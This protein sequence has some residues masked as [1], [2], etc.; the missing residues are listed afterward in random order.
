MGTGA[1]DGGGSLMA[2]F[3]MVPL[4]A[5]TDRTLTHRD[6]RTLLAVGS[7]ANGRRGAVTASQSKLAERA[8]ISR[9]Q[10]NA[11]VRTLVEK[12]Y[13]IKTR[14]FDQETGA[15]RP[16][17]I[18][19][20]LD[21]PTST[22]VPVAGTPPVLESGT[23][24]VPAVVTPPVLTTET[25]GVPTVGTQRELNYQASPSA[26]PPPATLEAEFAHAA[27]RE[28]YLA[29]RRAH[30]LPAAFDAGLR[31]VHAPI[32]G[33]A[34]FAWDVIGAGLLQLQ[35]NGE[36][37]NVSRLR[38]YCR[39]HLA[40][41]PPSGRRGS[42]APKIAGPADAVRVGPQLLSAVGVWQACVDVGLTSPMLSR[43]TIDELVGR[44]VERGAV[45][46]RAAFVSLVLE[47]DPA[48]LA[49]IKFAKTREDRLRERLAAWAAKAPGRA[50]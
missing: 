33:G 39:S 46:D 8:G 26:S 37:F 36:T 35:A 48:S 16:A 32:T 7:F 18:D 11:S 19:L 2:A 49:E 41:A 1:G 43:E 4:R 24:P 45:Q 9:Q 6:L 30:R 5:L 20:I 29:L 21:E 34:A 22:R 44:L 13:L 14:Q 42:S 27:H 12:G 15:E 40:G 31:D 38:G 3:C 10:L 28:A 25:P 17:E 47:V 23:P 50:A